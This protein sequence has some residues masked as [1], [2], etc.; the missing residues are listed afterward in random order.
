VKLL[1]LAG[2]VA[3][4]GVVALT[5]D[6]YGVVW[7]DDVQILDQRQAEQVRGQWWIHMD[8]QNGLVFFQ[9]VGSGFVTSVLTESGV[10][11]GQ[12]VGL[13]ITIGR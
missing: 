10:T 7:D 8:L 13:R 6:D 2:L 12:M 11:P 1:A 9:G 5:Y 3:A 4:L